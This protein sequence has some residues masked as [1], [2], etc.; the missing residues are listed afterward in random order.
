MDI[1]WLFRA[2]MTPALGGAEVTRFDLD[3]EFDPARSSV[4]FPLS[5]STTPISFIGGHQSGL[6]VVT[7]ELDGAKGDLVPV[8]LSGL[9]TQNVAQRPGRTRHRRRPLS[10]L[11]RLLTSVCLGLSS[12]HPVPK[13]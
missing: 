7:T 2:P 9:E 10:F 1:L 11:R 5:G 3:V 6:M 12:L 4:G 8:R 13:D